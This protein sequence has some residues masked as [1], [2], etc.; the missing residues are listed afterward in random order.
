MLLSKKEFF[1][2]LKTLREEFISKGSRQEFI[3]TY[4]DRYG[5]INSY[6]NLYNANTGINGIKMTHDEIYAEYLKDN[7]DDIRDEL[8]NQLIFDIIK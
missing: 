5:D 4:W 8:I 3:K 2:K 6:F 7:R 1:E